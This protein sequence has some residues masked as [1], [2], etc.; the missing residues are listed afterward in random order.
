MNQPALKR[1]AGTA[2]RPI[3]IFR[4]FVGKMEDQ[5]V[6]LL[7]IPP[8]LSPQRTEQM[9]TA[10]WGRFQQIVVAS[11]IRDPE[12]LQCTQLSLFNACKEAALAGLQ[13]D[14]HEA[15]ILAYKGKATF[16]P[17]VLG[18]AKKVRGSGE[19]DDI[20][21]RVVR[22]GDHFEYEEGD[23]PF[24]KHKPLI[25]QGLHDVVAAYSIC[26][27]KNGTLSRCVMDIAEIEG[28]RIK[29][30]KARTGPWTSPETYPRMCE[31]TVFRRHS[32]FLPQGDWTSM[33]LPG[34]EFEGEGEDHAPLPRGRPPARVSDALAAFADDGR[35]I[36]G[37]TVKEDGG[38]GEQQTKQQQPAG[39]QAAPVT[40]T[41]GETGTSTGGTAHDDDGVV[42]EGEIVTDDSGGGEPEEETFAEATTRVMATAKERGNTV[43]TINASIAELRDYVRT[44]DEA[45]ML[46]QWWSGKIMRD[47][48]TKAG[49]SVDDAK[50]IYDDITALVASKE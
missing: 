23:T 1:A 35:T 46:Q 10:L 6:P 39:K 42:V 3:D 18:I 13:P 34:S 30:S 37:T 44:K 45:L 26:R 33:L 28:I 24:I 40:T 15:V 8:T 43:E 17:M 32:K 5:I 19:I 22:A 11:A 12:I 4:G 20:W 9:R 7:P 31:K 50:K 38:E 47:L 48:R 41:A 29:Y 25:G 14:G 36:D 16:V 27:F 21:A 2:A 49:Y